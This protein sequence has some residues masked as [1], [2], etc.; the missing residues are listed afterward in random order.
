MPRIKEDEVAETAE[1]GEATEP[2]ARAP[3]VRRP[4]PEGVSTGLTTPKP[5][6]PPARV[7]RRGRTVSSTTLDTI[8]NL[9][10]NPGQWFEIGVY[11]SATPPSKESALGQHGFVFSHS[12]NENGTYTRLAMYPGDTDNAA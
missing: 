3:R 8:A 6:D 5:V 11:M 10:A 4:V 7:G 2:Q 1:T 9:K 12:P